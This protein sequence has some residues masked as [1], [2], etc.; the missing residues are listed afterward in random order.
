[1]ERVLS[2]EERLRKLMSD[3]EREAEA[4]ISEAQAKADLMI[5]H[6]QSEADRRL[7]MAQRGS[8]IDELKEIEEEKAKKEAEVI[9]A[10]YERKAEALKD[11]SSAKIEEAIAIILKEVL[12]E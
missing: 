12:P 9:L 3:A 5:S 7:R 10:D 1:M 8:G 11:V 2:L 4:K 6:A